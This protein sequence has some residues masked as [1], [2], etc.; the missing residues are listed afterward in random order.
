MSASSYS[1]R[2]LAGQCRQLATRADMASVVEALNEMA[3]DYDRQAQRADKA[4]ARTPDLP[5]GRPP[6]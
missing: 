3:V 6:G 2:A 1:L 4:E 5:A